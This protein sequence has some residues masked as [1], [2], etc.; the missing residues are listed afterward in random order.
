MRQHN[1]WHKGLSG[2]LHGR[3]NPRPY[4]NY[5]PRQDIFN[6][7]KKSIFQ[8]HK[9]VL[10]HYRIFQFLPD[11]P[12]RTFPPE[13][14][15]TR[16]DTIAKRHHEDHQDNS[17]ET[18][19]SSSSQSSPEPQTSA[20]Q[21]FASCQIPPPGQ[22]RLRPEGSSPPAPPPVQQGQPSADEPGSSSIKTKVGQAIATAACLLKPGRLQVKSQWL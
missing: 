13:K 9:A 11:F 22:V 17:S 4:I 6:Q 3:N 2:P 7:E 16:G 1:P 14:P 5:L 10:C 21:E 18:T 19:T 12:K 20:G 15:T 8:S